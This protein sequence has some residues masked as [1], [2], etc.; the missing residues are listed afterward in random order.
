M[1]RTS[2]LVVVVCGLWTARTEAVGPAYYPFYGVPSSGYILPAAYVPPYAAGYQVPAR[3][4]GAGYYGNAQQEKASTQ[5]DQQDTKYYYGGKF[6]GTCSIDGLYYKDDTTFVICSNGY[7]SE[8]P[9]PPGTKTAGYPSYQAGYY[10]GY[11]DLCSINLVD[12]GYGPSAYVTAAADNDDY[13]QQDKAYG[14]KKPSSYSSYGKDTYSTPAKSSS[15]A[16]PTGT[17]PYQTP[18]APSYPAVGSYPSKLNSGSEY[19]DN[20]YKNVYPQVNP[21]VADT[22]SKNNYQPPSAAASSSSYSQ[23]PNSNPYLSRDNSYSQQS[24]GNAYPPKAAAAPATPYGGASKGNSYQQSNYQVKGSSYPT[25][26]NVYQ[27]RDDYAKVTYPAA[28]APA[29]PSTG[30]KRY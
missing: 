20:E 4:A 19:R 13:R 25:T 23:Q 22:T 28:K 11:T 30:D 12:Y 6:Q 17:T 27:A 15:P 16:Y 8:Q 14:E 2:L 10:Y 26:D 1:M 9:C 7:A 29:Y 24:S 5:Y 18:K 21:Y 3:A